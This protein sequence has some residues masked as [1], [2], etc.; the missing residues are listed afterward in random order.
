[1]EKESESEIIDKRLKKAVIIRML[2]N[3]Q[4]FQQI[5]DQM[6][7]QLFKAQFQF[8]EAYQK[9]NHGIDEVLRKYGHGIEQ[10]YRQ[11]IQKKGKVSMIKSKMLQ[12]F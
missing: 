11:F 9:R 8:E 2:I 3:L 10:A 4:A 5:Q 12:S 6:K 1:M 7:M